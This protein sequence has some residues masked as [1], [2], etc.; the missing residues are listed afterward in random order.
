MWMSFQNTGSEYTWNNLIQVKSKDLAYTEGLIWFVG[1]YVTKDI[2]KTA[3]QINLC[4][5]HCLCERE[6]P[7]CVGS[8]SNTVLPTLCG[9][10]GPHCVALMNYTLIGYST[11]ECVF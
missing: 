11:Q 7:H 6:L 2:A 1:K 5:P 8:K 10:A 4:F 9:Q 3:R